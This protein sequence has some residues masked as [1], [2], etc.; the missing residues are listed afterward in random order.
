VPFDCEKEWLVVCTQCCAVVSRELAG[1]P[2]IQFFI[3]KPAGHYKANSQE[4]AGKTSTFLLV[5]AGL[6]VAIAFFMIATIVGNS[7]LRPAESKPTF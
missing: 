5:G 2:Y 1:D 3:A 4:A 6:A 7:P